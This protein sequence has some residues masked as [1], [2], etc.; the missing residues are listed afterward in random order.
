MII[1]S[2]LQSILT[3]RLLNYRST[4]TDGSEKIFNNSSQN[5]NLSVAARSAKMHD[6]GLN[7]V[8]FGL[9]TK[10]FNASRLVEKMISE[11][12]IVNPNSAFFCSTM[13]KTDLSLRKQLI[14]FAEKQISPPVKA[15][16]L[17]LPKCFSDRKQHAQKVKLPVIEPSCYL[18]K[19]EK[20]NIDNFLSDSNFIDN[21]SFSSN[22]NKK[23]GYAF[24]QSQNKNSN[25]C[26]E[27]KKNTFVE[28]QQAKNKLCKQ[29]S[30]RILPMLADKDRLFYNREACSKTLD[31]D[32]HNT[33]NDHYDGRY[34]IK[35]FQC[36]ICSKFFIQASEFKSHLIM[37]SDVK[38]F[39]CD[40][41]HKSF[42][43]K[44]NL[45]QHYDMHSE[46]KPYQCDI[47]HKYY[48]SKGNLR[49]HYA[50]HSKIKP[51]QCEICYKSFQRMSHLKI[52][53]E[54]HS[55]DAE[56]VCHICN[57]AFRGKYNLDRHC[58]IHG[59][60]GSYSCKICNKEFSNRQ[61]IANHMRNHMRNHKR[62]KS[63]FKMCEGV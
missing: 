44:Q 14:M 32:N 53:Y 22:F 54:T 60:D 48:K 34:E 57:K 30:S 39:Q 6:F 45:K 59:A 63:E 5:L 46:V 24:T 56:L 52:H 55:V 47:C 58:K 41:C 31:N 20:N 37:H 33:L 26:T 15:F 28:N 10:A 40:I 27:Y 49:G 1:N 19:T 50:I 38:P 8:D 7:L 9:S 36:K 12:D 61:K 11:K 3:S 51:F 43:R 62:T 2:N 29:A 23:H 13:I 17:L 21:K 4:S 25:Y 35:P 42:K 16:Q 18:S